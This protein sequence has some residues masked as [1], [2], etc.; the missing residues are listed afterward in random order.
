MG[1]IE[2]SV[3]S[4]SGRADETDVRIDD[5]S[6][7]VEAEAIAR[8]NADDEIE[9]RIDALDEKV[10]RNDTSVRTLISELREETIEKFS[11]METADA[12]ITA[13]VEANKEDA[14]EKFAQN[15]SEHAQLTSLIENI[16]ASAGAIQE[17]FDAFVSDTS[18]K[19]AAI[20]GDVA[21]E[22]VKI[23]AL[24]EKVGRIGTDVSAMFDGFTEDINGLA[25]RVGTIEG[26]YVSGIQKAS[27]GGMKDAYVFTL[28]NEDVQ[29]DVTVETPSD[30]FYDYVGSID[31]KTDSSLSALSG[32]I[33]EAED[34][35]AAV[36]EYVSTV[37]ASLTGAI[38]NLGTA[39]ASDISTVDEKV[40]ALSEYVQQQD[41][42][43]EEKT[44][45]LDASLAMLFE[46][47]SEIY[48]K[49]GL[50]YVIEPSTNILPAIIDEIRK[51]S[52]DELD[53]RILG[54]EPEPEPEPP[55]DPGY[56]DGWREL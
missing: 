52:D 40:D 54:E 1:T 50:G 12:S 29:T 25:E 45:R 21:E 11:V 49:L 24:D 41:E 8:A 31:G 17:E 7:L 10:G 9:G 13:A 48:D 3:A 51:I 39:L 26:G 53:W 35:I 55:Y 36:R 18:V 27:N 42:A 38:S 46:M 28:K 5:V 4:L 20:A 30:A 47:V 2:S 19:I 15:E 6:S 14:D 44:E 23:E 22:G 34:E 32:R 16:E 56:D 33:D 37:D 43:L